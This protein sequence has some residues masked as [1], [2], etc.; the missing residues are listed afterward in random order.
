M[1]HLNVQAS[2]KGFDLCSNHGDPNSYFCAIAIFLILISIFRSMDIIS[3]LG[4]QD[5]HFRMVARTQDISE[6]N[7]IS[8]QYAMQ[9]FDVRIVKKAQ[10][11]LAIYEV[12][13]AKAPDILS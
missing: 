3:D 1:R 4:P 12:W 11:N 9:G 13:I 6:A 7:R 5:K 10:G 8:D 2:V